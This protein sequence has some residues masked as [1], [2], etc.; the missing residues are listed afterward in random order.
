MG[1]GREL[2]GIQFGSNFGFIGHAR[3]KANRDSKRTDDGGTGSIEVLVRDYVVVPR[4]PLPSSIAAVT[5]EIALERGKRRR[6]GRDAF[7]SFSPRRAEVSHTSNTHTHTRVER[8]RGWRFASSD[9]EKGLGLDWVFEP[10]GLLTLS[11][12]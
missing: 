4:S 6:E 5:I 10:W 1:G 2:G 11:L 12:V 3:S 9:R 8:A 7:V